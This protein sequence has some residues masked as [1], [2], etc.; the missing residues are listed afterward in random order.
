MRKLKTKIGNISVPYFMQLNYDK[1]C[2][3]LRNI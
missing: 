2:F 1:Y 3:L